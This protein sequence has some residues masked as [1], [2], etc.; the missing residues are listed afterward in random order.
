M[1]NENDSGNDSR[2]SLSDK[3]ADKPTD[4]GPKDQN[5]VFEFENF[6]GTATT[7]DSTELHDALLVS[8]YLAK[9]GGFATACAS[10]S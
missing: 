6:D 8:G 7:L 3:A 5:V 1:A 2:D 10:T 4:V 9:G